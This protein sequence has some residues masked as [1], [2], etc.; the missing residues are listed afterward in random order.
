MILDAKKDT[1]IWLLSSNCYQEAF[2]TLAVNSYIRDVY[3]MNLSRT[4]M[5][6]VIYV[7]V[8]KILYL[9]EPV[10][11]RKLHSKTRIMLIVK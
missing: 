10:T 5:Y 7:I 4:S 3:N 6:A 1:R 2:F 9:L 8:N 11:G